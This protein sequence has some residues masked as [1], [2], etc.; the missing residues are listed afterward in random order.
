METGMSD[1][2]AAQLYSVTEI[3]F[4]DGP[5]CGARHRKRNEHTF[6]IT[7]QYLIDLLPA[8]QLKLC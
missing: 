8:L 1:S 2:Q 7:R 5:T 6:I 3:R 4:L